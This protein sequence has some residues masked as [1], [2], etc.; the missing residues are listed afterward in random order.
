[1]E[2]KLVKSFSETILNDDLKAISGE[3][4]EASLDSIVDSEVLQKVP[5]VG[6]LLA[7]GKT[8]MILKNRNLIR[9]TLQF[10]HELNNRSIDEE[11][12]VEFSE[13]IQAGD[14]RAQEEIERIMLILDSTIDLEKSIILA[15]LVA[16]YINEIISYAEFHELTDILNRFYLSDKQMLLQIR[17]SIIT[18]SIG[19]EIYRV[20]RLT[21]MGLIDATLKMVSFSNEVGRQDK[22]VSISSIGMLFC[23][24]GFSGDRV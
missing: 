6:T 16:A 2:N 18:D 20:E 22:Y 24:I 9:Q 19:Q 17:T 21:G 8:G 5:I 15:R 10:M 23:D 3:L 12:K 14:K 1:M 13:R 11:K 4:L 7:I